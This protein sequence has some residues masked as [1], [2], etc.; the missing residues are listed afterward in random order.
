MPLLRPPAAGSEDALV[1]GGDEAGEFISFPSGRGL[2]FRFT[3]LV[4]MVPLSV[5]PDPLVPR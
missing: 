4:R 1:E 2:P 5:G 3:F